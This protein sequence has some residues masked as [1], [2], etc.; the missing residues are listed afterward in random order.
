MVAYTEGQFIHAAEDLLICLNTAALDI[1][2]PP[3]NSSLRS[4]AA[5]ALDISQNQNECCD[6]LAWVRIGDEFPSV[7]F[8]EQDLTAANCGYGVWVVEL[9]M[10]IARCA[11]VGDINNTPT[12]E[13]H[14][15]LAQLLEEDAAAMRR[16]YCC[17]TTDRLT[18]Q[19]LGR[20]A[21]FGPEGG[22]VGTIA[23][24]TVQIIPREDFTGG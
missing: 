6:G 9:E 16:A 15:A 8:P 17:F 14:Y 22:C 4:G 10:G 2:S 23:T 5:I 3:Q 24:V 21:K 13:E 18:V 11:P 7:V 19:A 20:L 1:S 12:Y